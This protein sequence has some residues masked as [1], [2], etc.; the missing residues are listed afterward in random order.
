TMRNAVGAMALVCLGGVAHAAATVGPL[1][2]AVMD[3][4][5]A[6]TAPEFTPLGAGLQSMITTDL[7]ELPMF[8]LVERARLKDIQA[9]LHL[10]QSGAIDKATA[11]KIGSLAGA[12]HL[13]VG[14]FTVVGGKMRLDA[15][16]FAVGTGEVALAEKMEGAQTSFF[17]LEQKLVRKII[18]SVGVKLGKKEKA[19]LQKPQTTDFEAFAKYSQG[20]ALADDKKI[21]EAV[22]AMQA[23]VQ[24]DPNFALAAHKLADLQAL[25]ASLPPSPKPPEALQCKPNPLLSQPCN[26]PGQP[27]TAQPTIFTGG[28]ER[29][30]GV[31]VRTQGEEARCLTPCQLYLPPGQATVEVVTPVHYTTTVQVPN[32]PAHL[33]VS[34]INKT[35]IIIGS[36]LAGIALGATA[37]TIGLHENTGSTTAS[38]AEEFWPLTFAI[39]T[40]AF[41]PAVYYFMKMGSNSAKVKALP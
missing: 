14:S 28:D 15:R 18:D 32:A 39:A 4:T 21:A 26:T 16:L 12:S 13:L 9:E 36:V 41:F 27:P 11:A 33:T 17:D 6:S 8:V 24:K 37:A 25:L 40:S 3:F 20:L 5:P 34:G 7:G 10:S 38:T 2:V 30:F 35:N 1:R 22:A 19:D 23:A 29:S 31:V